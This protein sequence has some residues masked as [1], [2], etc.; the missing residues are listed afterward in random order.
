VLETRR[1]KNKNK[2]REKN[3]AAR[4]SFTKNV[5]SS[6]DLLSVLPYHVAA[7]TKG[8]RL[9]SSCSFVKFQHFDPHKNIG[10]VITPYSCTNIAV[11]ISFTFR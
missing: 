6:M 4:W 2:Y 3:C 7:K 11:G 9:V 8:I 1:V 5:I 10:K